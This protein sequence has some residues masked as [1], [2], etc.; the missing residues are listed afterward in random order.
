MLLGILRYQDYSWD[1]CLKHSD[2]TLE[3]LT[4]DSMYLFFES[5]I[6]GGVSTISKR[7][8]TANNPYLVDQTQYRPDDEQSYL[9]YLDANNLYGYAMKQ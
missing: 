9:L 3:L 1:S 8:A 4:D 5:S 7:F 2:K 6:R